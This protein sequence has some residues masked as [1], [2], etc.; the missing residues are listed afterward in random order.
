ML[1]RSKVGTKGSSEVSREEL[2]NFAF[3]QLR[4][5][6]NNLLLCSQLRPLHI[7]SDTAPQWNES[8]VAREEQTS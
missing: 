5:T 8:E 2:A 4:T 7:G 6:F 3:S 1:E